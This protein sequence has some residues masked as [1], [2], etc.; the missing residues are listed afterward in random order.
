[1]DTG[2]RQYDNNDETE[3]AIKKHTPLLFGHFVMRII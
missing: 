2:L 3:Q 1:M